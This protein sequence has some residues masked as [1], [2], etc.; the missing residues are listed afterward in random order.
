MT[1]GVEKIIQQAMKR[2]VESFDTAEICFFVLN[3]VRIF[4]TGL[5]LGSSAK[6]TPLKIDLLFNFIPVRVHL[7]KYSENQ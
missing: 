7:H 2:G 1:K 4:R 3:H 6:F 5:Y